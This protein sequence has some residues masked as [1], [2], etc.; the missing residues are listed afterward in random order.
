[1]ETKSAE[2][3]VSIIEKK[4]LF[5]MLEH[6]PHPSCPR[7]RQQNEWK[8]DKVKKLLSQRLYDTTGTKSTVV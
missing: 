6:L 5:L 3:I 2:E 7:K 1:M 4:I 8:K